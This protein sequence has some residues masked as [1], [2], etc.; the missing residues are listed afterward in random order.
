MT[1]PT[2]LHIS[3]RIEN[4]LMGR[5]ASVLRRYSWRPLAVP[6]TGYGSAPAEGE[7]WARVLVRV[8][9]S[10]LNTA[11]EDF[12]GEGGR[13]WRKFFTVG[14]ADVPVSVQLGSHVHE[15]RSGRGGY[16]DV[17]L[18]SDLGPGWHDVPMLVAGRPTATAHLRVVGPD[19]RFGM[20]SDIDDT[21]MITAL[22]RPLLAFWNTFVVKETSRRPVPGMA[23]LYE[24]LRRE[25]PDALVVYLSTGAWNVAR[26][27]SRF[28]ELHAYP[29]GPLVM[30]DWGRRPTAGSVPAGPT[31][32]ASCVGWSR[33]SRSCAGC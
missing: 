23:V 2:P 16:V 1:V 5:I 7:G 29:R 21:V 22:P 3:A 13:W 33:S 24:R 20:V 17:V 27:I 12:D 8:R 32:T 31:S 11:T 10:P 25:E 4:V 26:A 14:L 19:E 18:P 28:L 6:Y 9:L 30:T 15:V